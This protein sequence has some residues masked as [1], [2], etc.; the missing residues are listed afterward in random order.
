MLRFLKLNF[1]LVM[2]LAVN[3]G[4]SCSDSSRA[5]DDM[6][7]GV[8]PSIISFGSVAI[9]S[10]KSVTL[11][12][13]HL[14]SSGEILLND[15]SI[16]SRSTEFTFDEPTV[17][18]LGVGESTTLTVWYKPVD[19]VSDSGELIISHNV[20]QQGFKTSVKITAG[21]FVAELISEPSPIDFGSVKQGTHKDLDVV[22]KN[23]GSDQV[24]ITQLY[25]DANGSTDFAILA[26]VHEDGDSLPITILPGGSLG[27]VLRY[28]PKSDEQNPISDESFL[29][30]DGKSN[31]DKSWRF[32][33]SGMEL[34]PKLIL[35]PGEVDFGWVPLNQ[36]EKRLIMMENIGN[37][38][39]VID[40]IDFLPDANQDLSLE[41]VSGLPLT[42]KPNESHDIKVVW[43]PKTAFSDAN[44]P[45][46]IV[47][48]HSNDAVN[49]LIAR[50]F[51]RI[52]SP[53]I[54][55]IPDELEFGFGAQNVPVE[56][57]LTIRND[58]YGILRIKDLAIVDA[59]PT[60]YGDEFSFTVPSTHQKN[61]DGEY[62]IP[63]NTAM[64][65]TMIF[66]NKGPGQGSARA[67]LEIVSNSP[68]SDRL[69]VPLSAQR[70]TSPECKLVLEPASLTFGTVP[71]GYSKDLPINLKNVGSGNCGFKSARIEDCISFPGAP[72]V[73]QTPGAKP[74]SQKFFFLGIPVPSDE[75]IKPGMSI[76]LRVMFAP[77]SASTLWGDLTQYAAL[78]SVVGWDPIKQQEF[79]VPANAA[80]EQPNPN[81]SGATGTVN[82][83]V[84]PSSI[85]FGLVTVGCHSQ[86][87]RVCVYNT[88]TAALSITEIKMQGCSPEFKR[89]N[90][91][92]LPKDL[93]SLAPV[94]FELVYAPQDLTADECVVQISS[95]DQTS[96]SMSIGIKGKGTYETEQTDVFQQVSG[97][98]VDVLFVIDDSGSMCDEQEKMAENFQS[99]IQHSEVWNNDYHIGVVST[100][101][102]DEHIRGKLNL[103]D[104]R[105]TPRFITKGPN[106]Q[107]QFERLVNLGCDSS[108]SGQ[109]E[110]GFQAAQAA[111]TA[112]L[113]TETGVACSSDND[114]K[115][116]TSLCGKPTNCP[117][118]C[119]DGTC[120]GWN[121]GF[122]RPDAQLEIVVMSD[123]EDQSNGTPDFY[124]DFFKSLKGYYNSNMMHFNAIVGEDTTGQGT[125]TSPD[126]QT[127]AG[128]GKRYKY[129]VEETDG[130]FGSIC[131]P[132][133]DV[134]MNEI[135]AVAFGLKVQFYLSRLADPSAVDVKVKGVECK[136]GWRYDVASNSVI[137][138]EE[139]P[140]MPQ[141]GDEIRIHYE[142]LCLKN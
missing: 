127:L 109:Q 128:D 99:F 106:A 81:I 54:F 5:A 135:G 73:C 24:E 80:T 49:P 93:T 18:K 86:T 25:L 133:F 67:K 34:G 98:T 21:G 124:I 126:G 141:P 85:D 57:M 44:A 65:L 104:A 71:A 36:T 82:L 58:G 140:C 118:S 37:D 41:G 95:N 72:L 38:D 74:P 125:C 83:S 32:D 131:D 52:E 28:T 46:G 60:T 129:V 138:D 122:M 120:G 11:T 31:G 2:L 50:V 142:T 33:V 30:V 132:D 40:D 97:Q 70:A 136:T 79:L 84:L 1:L 112:P 13:T 68:D 75:G 105:R 47:G 63:S 111:L 9:H 17:N 76:P 10:S 137:F 55:V 23:I 101:V 61:A 110:A 114:C 19:S 107:S 15:I 20:A 108:G 77:K 78:L 94:C 29:L 134:V 39:L 16:S 42:L 69:F 92:P 3:S 102:V 22:L 100:N 130:K 116:N 64:A 6:I 88:G 115:N 113:I 62:E 35:T 45:I 51:G 53:L 89:K 117:Y 96:P 8:N 119:L 14:G 7:L 59:N 12:L 43:A 26:I 27:L 56:R 121:K 66:T 139:G 87:H 123:E 103:G 4:C 90:V 91:P 48:F